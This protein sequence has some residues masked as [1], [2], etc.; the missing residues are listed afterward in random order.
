MKEW[1]IGHPWAS[2]EQWLA[3]MIEVD[4]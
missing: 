1:R 3:F 4:E 2:G